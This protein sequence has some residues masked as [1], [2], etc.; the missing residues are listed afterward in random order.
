MEIVRKIAFWL[1]AVAYL[2]CSLI[3]NGMGGFAVLTMAAER[4]HS[5]GVMLLI[6]TLMFT[7]ALVLLF[8]RKTAPDIAA[9]LFCAAGTVLYALPINALNS[10][11]NDNIT[12]ESINVLTSRIYPSA[13]VSVLLALAALLDIFSYDKMAARE[14]RRLEKNRALTEKERIV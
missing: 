12:R 7:I 6:S 13:A 8:F 11:V 4:F 2:V 3:L 1:G 10:V 5:I 9:L 14:A